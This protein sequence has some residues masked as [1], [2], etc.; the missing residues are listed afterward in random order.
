[1]FSARPTTDTTSD[2]SHPVHNF[3]CLESDCTL[4]YIEY[5]TR[6][7]CLKFS[8]PID[9]VNTDFNLLKNRSTSIHNTVKQ[10]FRI[11]LE[12]SKFYIHHL[13]SKN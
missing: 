7:K 6:T 9:C 13:K 10:L 1:M 2:S 5:T 11:D 12:A 4:M 3:Q 8:K